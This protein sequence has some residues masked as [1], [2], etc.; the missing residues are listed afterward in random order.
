[1]RASLKEK[2]HIPAGKGT[3]RTNLLTISHEDN[4][5]ERT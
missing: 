1:M 2:V 3:N 5:A 4:N